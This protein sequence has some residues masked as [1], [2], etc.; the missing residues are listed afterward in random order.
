MSQKQFFTGKGP[1][2]ALQY[3]SRHGACAGDS[4]TPEGIQSLQR[5]REILVEKGFTSDFVFCSPS[6]RCIQTARILAPKAKIS[7]LDELKIQNIYSLY[8][9]T[10][11]NDAA[12]Q[13][14]VALIDCFMPDLIVSHSCSPIIIALKLIE[15]RS[16]AP[17]DWN[18]QKYASQCLQKGSGV[19]VHDTQFEYIDA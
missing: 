14:I 6:K 5:T 12:Y 4:L 2:M 15:R 19:L 10:R 3:F 9:D 16:I 13:N 17:L 18:G 1:R 8:L 7:E 11:H